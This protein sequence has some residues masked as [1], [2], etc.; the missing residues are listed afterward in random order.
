MFQRGQKVKSANGGKD[1]VGDYIKVEDCNSQPCSGM[2]PD[3]VSLIGLEVFGYIT[4]NNTFLLIIVTVDCT[5]SSWSDWT[6]CSKTCGGGIKEKSRQVQTPA[7]NGGS[8]CPKSDRLSRIACNEH[9]CPGIILSYIFLD[10]QNTT[11]LLG[12]KTIFLSIPT[13][14]TILIIVTVNCVWSAWS[15]WTSCSKTCENGVSERSRRVHTLAQNGGS[16]CQGS[17]RQT[18]SCIENDCPGE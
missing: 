11:K 17:A 16:Q 1:C 12:L 6:S 13:I 4:V 15:E 3:L 10:Y 14:G 7:E 9:D 5:W 2:S 8:R 18:K